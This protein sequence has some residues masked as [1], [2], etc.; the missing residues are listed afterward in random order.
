MSSFLKI[1]FNKQA[2]YSNKGFLLSILS[3]KQ[4]VVRP[5]VDLQQSDQADSGHSSED[6]KDIEDESDEKKPEEDINDE[7][8]KNVEAV[9]N[10]SKK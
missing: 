1:H 7:V 3:Q 6:S 8:E 5:H 4:T 9:L 2:K 10:A